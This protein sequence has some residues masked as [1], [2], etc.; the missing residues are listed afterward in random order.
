MNTFTRTTEQPSLYRHLETMSVTEIIT[1]INEEDKKVALAVE[2][3][4]PQLA[5]LIEATADRM[6]AGGR[7]FYI[8]AGASGRTGVLDASEC[9]PT[10]G[11]RSAKFGDGN[12]SRRKPCH[13]TG[14]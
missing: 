10:F 13:N 5:K 2:A 3:A 11:V 1:H 12:Y 9:P 7:L 14:G 8:G 4:L 6:L